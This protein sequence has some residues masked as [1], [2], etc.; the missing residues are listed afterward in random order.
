[1]TDHHS[2]ITPD[3]AELVHYLRGYVERYQRQHGRP[4]AGVVLGRAEWEA[5]GRP[6][7]AAGVRIKPSA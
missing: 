5:L 3:A 1:M 4:P 6:E 7:M 2:T